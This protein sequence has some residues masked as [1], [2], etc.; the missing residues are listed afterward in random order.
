MFLGVFFALAAALGLATYSLS[1]STEGIEHKRALENPQSDYLSLVKIAERCNNKLE[2][3]WWKKSS[4]YHIY[5]RSFK[6]SN[7]DGIGDLP[8][9]IS[10]L[11]YLSD[12]L[13]IDA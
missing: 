4:F 7:Q 10:K 13:G 1:P 8:G 12:I 9:L 2:K 11:D 5:L 3:D 6:D